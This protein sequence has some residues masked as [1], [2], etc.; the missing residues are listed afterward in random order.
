M[1][2]DSLPIPNLIVDVIKHL[3]SLN[4]KERYEH[5]KKVL[6]VSKQVSI[7]K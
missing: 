7:F 1:F 5:D 4:R 3:Q 6:P 2:L